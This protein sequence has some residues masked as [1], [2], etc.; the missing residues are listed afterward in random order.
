MS[1]STQF[2]SDEQLTAFIDGELAPD[3]AARIEALVQTDARV[4]ERFELL[5]RASLPFGAAF[6]PLLSQAPKAALEAMLSAIPLPA[7]AKSEPAPAVAGR[8]GF[9]GA[10]AACLVA[11]VIADRAF[12]GVKRQLAKGDEGSEWRAVVAEYI[13]LYTPDTLVGPVP[14]NAA[15]AAQLAVLETKL[16]LPLPPEAIALPDVDF[17]RALLLQYDDQPLAQIAYLDPETGPLAL[18]IVRS[19]DGAAPPRVEGRKG[20]NV[21][22][23]ATT[24]HAFMLIGHAPV[25][26]MQALAADV[27]MRL[28]V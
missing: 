21:V 11:G 27:R 10:L 22:Y 6:E 12:I 18:C 28:S 17:K 25:D 8:R 3:E 24:A 4:A 14:S 7:S 13:A 1:E 19:D 15:Q 5:S 23:W 26:R 20:M 9:L 16:G 2:P